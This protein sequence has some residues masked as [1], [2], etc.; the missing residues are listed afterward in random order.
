MASPNSLSMMLHRTAKS[1]G[2]RWPTK[3]L[4]SIMSSTERCRDLINDLP[5]KL[6]A[7][8]QI[9]RTV[10]KGQK[11]VQCVDSKA[12]WAK[13]YE[14]WMGLFPNRC[15]W[16]AT[17]AIVNSTPIIPEPPQHKRLAQVRQESALEF[18]S[19]RL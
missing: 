17:Q 11:V 12:E 1:I 2:I 15:G 7:L 14:A 6:D 4:S 9:A 19:G 10:H 18:F 3:Y 8:C 16:N 13:N 5:E